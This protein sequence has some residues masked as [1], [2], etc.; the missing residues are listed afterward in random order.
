LTTPA[1]LNFARGE[2]LTTGQESPAFLGLFQP[3]RH[4][5]VEILA[6]DRLTGFR[7][8]I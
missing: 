1:A 5:S 8:V 7:A 3:S 2:I 6:D 4:R